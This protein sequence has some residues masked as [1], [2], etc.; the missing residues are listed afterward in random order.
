MELQKIIILRCVQNV[1]HPISIHSQRKSDPCCPLLKEFWPT[2]PAPTESLTTPA[3][4][5]KKFDQPHLH[6]EK[7]CKILLFP[8]VWPIPPVPA[9]GMS[10]TLASCKKFQKQIPPSPGE[11]LTN[12]THSSRMFEQ[13]LSTEIWTNPLCSSRKFNQFHLSQL[14]IWPMPPTPKERLTNSNF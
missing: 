12:P 2:S 4:N 14:K 9:E 3:H 5:H 10:D 13:A 6:Q 1:F 7:M 8:K 11:R